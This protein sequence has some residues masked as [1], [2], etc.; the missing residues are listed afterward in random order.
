MKWMGEYPGIVSDNY[1]SNK[2]SVFLLSSKLGIMHI[3]VIQGI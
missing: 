1:N 3:V 2:K